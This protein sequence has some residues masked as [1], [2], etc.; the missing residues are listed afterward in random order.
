MLHR[1]TVPLSLS[2][3]PS[4]SSV[5]FRWLFAVLVALSLI[6]PRPVRLELPSVSASQEAAWMLA[7]VADAGSH[8]EDG[9]FGAFLAGDVAADSSECGDTHAGDHPYEMDQILS[10]FSPHWGTDAVQWGGVYCA[11]LSSDP[12][13]SID[14]P[15]KVAARTSGRLLI[16]GFAVA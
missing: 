6:M 13:F 10:L 4:I 7:S 2:D 11:R 14:R 9:A 8:A 3:F 12:V 5:R 1:S 15:P 16:E